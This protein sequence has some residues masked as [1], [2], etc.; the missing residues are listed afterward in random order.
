[1]FNIAQTGMQ[2]QGK[3]FPRGFCGCFA[4]RMVWE[5]LSI[6]VLEKR[7]DYEDIRKEP[8][9]TNFAGYRSSKIKKTGALSSKVSGPAFLIWF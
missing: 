6:K 8:G 7:P 5:F 3:M 2:E 1:M 9:L 4:R